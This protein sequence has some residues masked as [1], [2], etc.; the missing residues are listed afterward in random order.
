MKRYSVGICDSDTGYVVGFAE[1]VNMNDDI[2]VK[3]SAFS[4]MDALCEYLKENRLDLILLDE[5]KEF[6]KSNL[7]IV[8]LTD[9]KESDN[10]KYIYK[11]QSVYKIAE[12]IVRMLDEVNK[13]T[14]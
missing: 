12:Y 9:R 5:K 8:R 6:G 1:Y 7:K 10:E 4:G 13:K 14:E 3:V 11:Y 2:P